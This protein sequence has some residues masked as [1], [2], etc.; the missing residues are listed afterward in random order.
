MIELK[1]LLN[2]LANLR[3]REER[4]VIEFDSKQERGNGR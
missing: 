4:E 1:L 2:A 3:Q